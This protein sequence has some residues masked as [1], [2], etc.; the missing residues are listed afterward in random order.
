M[1]G[2]QTLDWVAPV[3]VVLSCSLTRLS[4]CSIVL[5]QYLSLVK[6]VFIVQH[7]LQYCMSVLR[8]WMMTLQSP[9]TYYHSVPIEASEEK[10]LSWL[11][12][13]YC[14]EMG[15]RNP[16]SSEGFPEVHV[17]HGHHCT[18]CECD[19]VYVSCQSTMLCSVYLLTFLYKIY[20]MLKLLLGMVPCSLQIYH[21]IHC[22]FINLF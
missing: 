12:V 9:L 14:G 22:L 21:F 4:C 10:I 8:L 17:A 20:H 2:H 7:H 15:G 19:G 16:L 13:V 1:A 5:Y 11:T 6:V 18:V 3:C